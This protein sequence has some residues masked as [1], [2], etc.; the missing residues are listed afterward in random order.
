[1][2][3]LPNTADLNPYAPSL[4]PQPRQDFAEAGVGLWRDGDLVVMHRDA[5]WPAVCVRTGE[6]AVGW[7]PMRILRTA[8]GSWLRSETIRFHLPV[9]RRWHWL[10]TKLRTGLLTA[11]LISLGALVT[12]AFYF[13]RFPSG[14][15]LSIA[16]G[17]GV[18]SIA[19]ILTSSGLAQLVTLRRDRGNYL[20]LTGPSEKFLEQLPVWPFHRSS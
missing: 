16:L 20:W 5:A 3:T 15:S 12:S 4:V 10:T 18:T 2:T 8:P 9:G 13:D 1:M 11:G 14:L 6:P 19:L 17:G 7:F